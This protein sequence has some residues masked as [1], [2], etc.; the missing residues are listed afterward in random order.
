MLLFITFSMDHKSEYQMRKNNH[1]TP[2][3][4]RRRDKQE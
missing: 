4:K 1:A 2:T 3:K